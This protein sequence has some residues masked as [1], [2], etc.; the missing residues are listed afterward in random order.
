M[1]IMNKHL[2]TIFIAI[3]LV[4]NIMA[5]ERSWKTGET[6]YEGL[7]LFLRFPD[8]LNF[9]LLQQQ[10]PKRI[11]V[12]HLLSEVT[13]NGS[14]ESNYNETLYEFDGYL[15][16]YLEDNGHGITVLVET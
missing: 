4:G 12:T 5:S 9:D 1:L 3:L 11:S 13:N 7:P 14:P 6:E 2:L 15:V 10:Y 16:N 8:K